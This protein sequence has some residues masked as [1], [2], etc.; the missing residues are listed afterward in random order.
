[1]PLN[2]GCV[3]QASDRLGEG[4]FWSAAEGRLWWFDIKGRRLSFYAP[5][6]DETGHFDLPVR[7]S[8]AAPRTGGGLVIATEAGLGAFDPASGE[9]A[10]VQP[11]SFDPGFRSNDGKLA[12]DGSFWWSI[13]D[14]DGGKRP[15]AF[16]RTTRDWTTERLIDD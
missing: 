7:A 13:M 4:P 9:F 12:P 15:G 14:D 16:F 8:A 11:H 3:V 10:I 5:E 1:G 2:L 6:C